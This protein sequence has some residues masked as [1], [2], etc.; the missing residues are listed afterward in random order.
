MIQDMLSAFKRHAEI[1]HDVFDDK[2]REFLEA[3]VQTIELH[4]GI[5]FEWQEITE[6][7]LIVDGLVSPTVTP[8][9]GVVRLSGRPV[10]VG[11]DGAIDCRSHRD[12]RR[13]HQQSVVLAYEAGYKT[14]KEVPALMRQA[15]FKL[16]L[17]LMEHRGDAVNRDSFSAT[18][19][20]M[21]GENNPLVDSGAAAL[22]KPFE[23]IAI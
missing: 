2:C 10:L 7:K 9:G 23:R 19:G 8:N 5:L 12:L 1:S 6:N 11:G 14:M 16:A 13:H 22:L 4:Y 18:M 21:V 17:H 3:A 20:A 15:A